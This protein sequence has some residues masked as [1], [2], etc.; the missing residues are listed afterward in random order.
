MNKNFK[1]LENKIVSSNIFMLLGTS[2]YLKDLKNRNS[3]PF[4]Q[5]MMAKRNKK[6]VLIVFLKGKIKEQEKIEIERFYSSF[7]VVKEIEI[8]FY[9]DEGIKELSDILKDMCKKMEKK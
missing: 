4:I 2:N 7:N 3:V 6:P 5:S 1:D 8:D 9:S